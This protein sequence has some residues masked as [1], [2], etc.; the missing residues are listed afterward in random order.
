MTIDDDIW[1]Y[2]SNLGLSL[3]TPHFYP[4][5]CQHHSLLLHGLLFVIK[6]EDPKFTYT[7]K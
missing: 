5:H 2:V 3:L 4:H 7:G 6:M 1:R